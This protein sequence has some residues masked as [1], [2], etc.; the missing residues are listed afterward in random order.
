[1]PRSLKRQ[2]RGLPGDFS[3]AHTKLMHKELG[4]T[5]HRNT[6]ERT[7]LREQLLALLFVKG[8]QDSA[9]IPQLLH[10]VFPNLNGL[11]ITFYQNCVDPV[12]SRNHCHNQSHYEKNHHKYREYVLI[13]RLRGGDCC[14]GHDGGDENHKQTV[15]HVQLVV[16]PRPQRDLS[17]Q[18]HQQ[19]SGKQDDLGLRVVRR[20]YRDEGQDPIPHQQCTTPVPAVR[21]EAEEKEA[22]HHQEI[23]GTRRAL[24]RHNGRPQRHRKEAHSIHTG[25]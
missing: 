25:E 2:P 4:K 1:M 11:H 23:S 6:A 17:Y 15:N 3:S 9:R 10:F 24:W 5:I 22:K 16:L 20:H 12:N 18:R 21:S 14:A 19:H 8:E 7:D 13:W